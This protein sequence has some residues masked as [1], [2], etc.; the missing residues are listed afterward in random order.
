MYFA[1]HKGEY[2]R[3]A[4][5]D[6]LTGPWK[7]YIPGSLHLAESRFLST[8]PA[9]TDEELC[10]FET[11]YQERGITLSHDILSEIT[12]P[13]IASPDVHVD[14]FAHLVVMYFHGLDRLGVQVSR[15]A[16]SHDGINFTTRPEVV[17]SSYMRI[18][19]H[20]GMI[21]ALTMPGTI[22]RSLDGLSG[23]EEGPNLF[24]PNMRHAAVHVR[25]DDLWIFWTQV[26][27]APE[28][29]LFSRVPLKGDW[30]T[31]R[32][33][34]AVEVLR[35]ERDWEGARAPIEPS[36]RSTAF[37]LVNQLRDPAIYEENQTL[38][39]L[40]AIGGESGIG[41]ARLDVAA[42]GK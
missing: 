19:R 4:Y 15:V 27:D 16:T 5:A 39:L 33:T 32:A 31:W 11:Q 30:H 17:G 34:A 23:F 21:Y 14:E 18:F 6:T 26:G 3:L 8:P 1:D 41:I 7:I 40:Y 42:S 25:A 36:V 13:H 9:V 12:T 37:G 20:D 2:I 28:R 22:S 29:I 10:H 24:N 38:Y 35:P